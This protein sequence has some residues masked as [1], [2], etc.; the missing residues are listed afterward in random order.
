MIPMNFFTPSYPYLLHK[1]A[2][3]E[4]GRR[5]RYENS[6]YKFPTDTILTVSSKIKHINAILTLT[7]KP[8]STKYTYF[9][10]SPYC[11]EREFL[12]YREYLDTKY[13][14]CY[15]FEESELSLRI[16]LNEQKY[17]SITKTYYASILIETARQR[18]PVRCY[19]VTFIKNYHSV[20]KTKELSI[21]VSNN[22][23]SQPANIFYSLKGDR[24]KKIVEITTIPEEGSGLKE[25]IIDEKT[26]EFMEIDNNEINSVYQRE[27]LTINSIYNEQLNKRLNS[28]GQVKVYFNTTENN[29]L[30][31]TKIQISIINTLLE[32]K[33]K[34]F[35]HGRLPSTGE[36]RIGK[37]YYPSE[38]EEPAKPAKMMENRLE[39]EVTLRAQEYLRKILSVD[40]ISKYYNH[41]Y[42]MVD[43]KCRKWTIEITIIACT[44]DS[45]I[46][47]LS[48]NTLIDICYLDPEKTTALVSNF[49]GYQREL[50]ILERSLIIPLH[51][52]ELFKHY[53]LK[54]PSGILLYGPPGTGKT[55]LA[56]ELARELGINYI[57]K[58]APEFQDKWVG[59]GQKAVRELFE[60]AREVSPCLIIIDE[61]DIIVGKRDN[62][63]E[64]DRKL[65][66]QFLTELDGLEDRE[67]VIIMGLTNRLDSI[68]PAIR[69]EGRFGLEIEL[70][71]PALQDR[72]EQLTEKTKELPLSSVNLYQI[73]DKTNGYSGADIGLLI[74]E[75]TLNSLKRVFEDNLELFIG[76]KNK[77]QNLPPSFFELLQIT[78]QDFS[79]VLSKIRPTLLKEDTIENPEITFKDIIGLAEEKEEISM[80]M[81]LIKGS[82]LEK[83]SSFKPIKGILLEGPPGTGKTLLAKA[84]A[85]EFQYSF[86]NIDSSSITSKYV[87][88]SEKEISNLFKRARAAAPCIIFIDEIDSILPERGSKED[89]GGVFARI[90]N[91]FLTELDG[92]KETRGILLIGATNRRDLLDTA[93]LRP[94]RIDKIIPIKLPLLEDI[95]LLL[96][97]ELGDIAIPLE[98]VNFMEEIIPSILFRKRV[99]GAQVTY[100]VREILFNS[101]N[102]I[103][104]SILITRDSINK[105]MN[106]LLRRVSKT[107]QTSL[108]SEF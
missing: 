9:N 3:K 82:M 5:S 7:L 106:N 64:H 73:A 35:I 92:L 95:K 62:A 57:Y 15:T 89:S 65:V 37:P 79:L 4:I 46:V 94:G 6:E 51:Y 33:N 24:S 21:C 23:L 91:Q 105:S 8:I 88:Q 81:R 101:F 66:T 52:P 54:P 96:K 18:I 59:E 13:Y 48:S 39:D 85:K 50:E 40:L 84:I 93:V 97:K 55:L 28:N 76:T 12:I 56:R 22:K 38:K 11:S 99:S 26:S 49:F 60:A 63:N 41:T 29:I 10:N 100:F 69:R 67:G 72:L 53:Q 77:K 14:Y 103:N 32:N 44:P 68:D 70:G 19:F 43:R 34:N 78:M 74:R 17:C 102:E 30:K 36:R 75:T 107:K 87:G 20:T 71:L 42:K 90:V 86:L 80:C 61:I 83:I 2:I 31:A 27:K 58:N 45:D 1:K 16:P 104:D 25:V 98:I 108:S 47:S